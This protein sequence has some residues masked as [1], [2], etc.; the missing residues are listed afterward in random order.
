MATSLPLPHPFCT[1]TSEDLALSHTFSSGLGALG[2]HAMESGSL[3]TFLQGQVLGFPSIGN[4]SQ[5]TIRTA[6]GECAPDIFGQCLWFE[7]Q[8]LGAQVFSLVSE[9]GE[10]L[11]TGLMK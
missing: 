3:S 1:T 2:D 10:C 5:G 4:W 9:A 8:A 6:P 7:C 11:L